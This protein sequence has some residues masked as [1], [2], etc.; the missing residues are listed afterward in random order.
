MS[1][2]NK[3]DEIKEA[4]AAATP[5]PWK[6]SITSVGR[7]EERLIATEY[8]HPQLHGPNGIVNHG[9]GLDGEFVYIK[10]E[11]AHFIAKSPE[12]ITYL[13]QEVERKDEA[14]SFFADDDNYMPT[15]ESPT[16]TMFSAVEKEGRKRAREAL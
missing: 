4:L 16:G 1:E 9:Y 7:H 11:D 13:L 14:L 12:Y 8:D 3:I 5:G 10:P 15:Y 2:Q 6:V